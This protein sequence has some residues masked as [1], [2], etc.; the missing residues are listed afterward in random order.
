MEDA[1]QGEQGRVGHRFIPVIENRIERRLALH[2]ADDG[3]EDDGH[4]QQRGK[5]S[6]EADAAERGE[7]NQDA[8]SQAK[9]N[10]HLGRS[11]LSR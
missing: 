1:D 10:Q 11:Q 6:A 9:A 8:H 4:R 7:N 2:G 5:A 3:A